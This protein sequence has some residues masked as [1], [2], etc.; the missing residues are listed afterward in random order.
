[1]GPVPAFDQLQSGSLRRAAPTA[2]TG[3]AA[4]GQKALF[5]VDI[6]VYVRGDGTEPTYLIDGREAR[7]PVFA[8]LTPQS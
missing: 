5:I 4:E 2:P 7:A 1:V 8:D 3:S 6:A